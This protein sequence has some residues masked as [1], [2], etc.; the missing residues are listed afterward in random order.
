MKK[1][2]IDISN[3]GEVRIETTG[4]QGEACLKESQ[5]IKDLLGLEKAKQLV[6]AY[7]QKAKKIIKKHLPLCG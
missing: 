1:I 4:F 7:Y 5:F 2:I 6:P 3:D